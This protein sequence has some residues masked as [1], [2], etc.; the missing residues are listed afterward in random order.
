MICCNVI[1][2][3]IIGTP[4]S[5]RRSCPESPSTRGPSRPLESTITYYSICYYSLV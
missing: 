3:Y 5:R 2:Y 4:P 1:V